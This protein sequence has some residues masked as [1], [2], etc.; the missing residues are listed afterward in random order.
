[1]SNND[2]RELWKSLEWNFAIPLAIIAVM[3]MAALL[4]L[5]V[6]TAVE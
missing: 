2:W 5:P 6:Q 3:T 1:M 4:L